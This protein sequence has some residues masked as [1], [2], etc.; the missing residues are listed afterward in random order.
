MAAP[1]WDTVTTRAARHAL[2]SLFAPPAMYMISLKR[3]MSS[4][5]YPRSRPW[6]ARL[7]LAKRQ[8][9]HQVQHCFP[10]PDGAPWDLSLPLNGF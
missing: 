2:G 7:V 4:C 6:L 8:Q 5:R 3:A 1:T 9:W 10:R